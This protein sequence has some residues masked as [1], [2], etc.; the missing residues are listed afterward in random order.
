MAQDEMELA[1]EG[2]G[3][4]RALRWSR[5]GLLTLWML[6]G[7]LFC[8]AVGQILG[9][10]LPGGFSYGGAVGLGLGIALGAAVGTRR[11]DANDREIVRR[12][13]EDSAVGDA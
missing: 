7:A 2:S 4:R 6:L 1:R 5:G 10:A 13:E 12:V 3:G 9:Q 11:A 8:A